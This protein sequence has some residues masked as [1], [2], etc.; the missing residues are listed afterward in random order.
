M[1]I[2]AQSTSHRDIIAKLFIRYAATLCAILLRSVPSGYDLAITIALPRGLC[3]L[4][5]GNASVMLPQ[6][7]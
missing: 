2:V 3:Y 7:S 1:S 6:C 5:V 4:G